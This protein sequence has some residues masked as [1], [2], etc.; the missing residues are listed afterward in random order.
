MK[1]SDAFPQDGDASLTAERD[2]TACLKARSCSYFESRKGC[3]DR[4]IS[5]EI[6]VQN[7]GM[8]CPDCRGTGPFRF[9]IAAPSQRRLLSRTP[10]HPRQ[11]GLKTPDSRLI[12][13]WL[14]CAA[15]LSN[16]LRLFRFAPTRIVSSAGILAGIVHV[17]A[18]AGVPLC[19]LVG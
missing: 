12:F 13:G 14:I 7:M 9:L 5:N 6:L 11:I 17:Q 10:P 1:G 16:Y 4:Q 3:K 2:I 15:V 19:K 18:M 8:T